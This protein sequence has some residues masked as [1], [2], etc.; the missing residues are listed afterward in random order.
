VSIAVGTAGGISLHA[1]WNHAA[2]RGLI[3][4]LAFYVSALS[5]ALVV[6]MLLFARRERLVRDAPDTAD[7]AAE[8]EDCCGDTVPEDGSRPLPWY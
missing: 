1:L 6:V 5:L 4:P 7:T 8:H 2:L 3:D